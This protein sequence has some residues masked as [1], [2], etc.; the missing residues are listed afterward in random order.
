MILLTLIWWLAALF[1]FVVFVVFGVLLIFGGLLALTTPNSTHAII[2]LF[3]VI[4]LLLLG[5][6]LKSEFYNNTVEQKQFPFIK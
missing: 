5:W 6:M 2:G 3:F 1:W 4:M